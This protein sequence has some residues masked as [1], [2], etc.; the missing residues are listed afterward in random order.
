[1]QKIAVILFVITAVFQWLVPVDMIKGKEDVLKNGTAFY[2][3]TQPID[4]VDFMRGRYINL[5][6]ENNRFVKDTANNDFEYN[7]KAYITVATAKTGESFAVNV[8]KEKPTSTSNYFKAKIYAYQNDSII[9]IYFPF[10]KFYMEENKA[11]VAETVY[12][13]NNRDILKKCFAKVFIKDGEFVLSDVL[14]DG[15]SIVELSGQQ[16]ME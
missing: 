6:F 11:P 16:A 7:E 1:M 14:I 13:E 12:N 5:Y 2:F 10:D 3:K 15:K 9:T 4:P 8:T